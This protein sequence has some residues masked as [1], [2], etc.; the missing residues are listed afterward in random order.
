[1]TAFFVPVYVEGDPLASGSIGAGVVVGPEAR[2]CVSDSGGRVEWEP[3][4][5][6]VSSIAGEDVAVEYSDPLPIARGYACSAAAAI[7]GAVASAVYRGRPIYKSL[8]IAHAME[9]IHRTGLGD[10]Q[11]ITASPI[12]GVVLRLRPGP[13]GYGVSEVIPI[14]RNVG[15]LSVEGRPV[16]TH[17]LLS[18]YDEKYR[19]SSVEALRRLFNEPT[20]EVFVEEATRHTKETGSAKSVVGS[21][22]DILRGIKGVIGYYAK[23]SVLVLFVE[24]DLIHDAAMDLQARLSRPA[25]ILDPNPRGLRVELL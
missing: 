11:S 20:F 25:R 9:V 6:T 22:L 17:V 23:K 15:I 2:V 8:R 7:G 18:L 3:L 10:V 16:E 12:G 21:D 19:R 5:S 24:G 13:P 14:P 1:V 4:A